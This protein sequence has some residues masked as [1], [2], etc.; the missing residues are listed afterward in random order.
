MIVRTALFLALVSLHAS[1]AAAQQ[2]EGVFTTKTI[3]LSSDIVTEQ[4]GDDQDKARE[5]LSALTVDQLV[6]LG[7]EVDSQQTQ[8]KGTR[9]RNA[10]GDMPGMGA[11]YMLINV[12]TGMMQMVMPAQRTYTEASLR[13]TPSQA[14]EEDSSEPEIEPLGRTQV[15]GG[16]RCTG[17]RVTDE[18]EVSI[19]WTTSDPAFRDVFETQMKIVSDDDAG[20]KRIRSLLARYGYPV[21]TQQVEEDGS[22]RVEVSSLER[23]PQADSLFAIPAGFRKTTGP[24]MR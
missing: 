9:M 10:I 3:R 17:Y 14:D 23:R 4:A 5:K 18:D 16:L 22:Y 8:V 24:G 6:R 19:M 12:G 21:M 1:V 11:G 2:F 20:V 7:A 13:G 15:I